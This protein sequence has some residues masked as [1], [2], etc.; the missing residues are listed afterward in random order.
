M[1]KLLLPLSI[2]LICYFN[3]LFAQQERVNVD[4]APFANRVNL[5]A[6]GASVISPE[7][8]PNRTVTFRLNAPN[9][10]SVSVSGSMFRASMNMRSAQMTKDEKGIW[11]VT[12]GPFEPD[13]YTYKFNVDGVSMIDPA[14]TYANQGS[15]PLS[16]ILYVHG[17]EPMYYDA[18]PGVPHGTV[19]AHYY[20]SEVT[21]GI[22]NLFVYTPPNYD[23]SKEYPVLYLMGGSGEIGETW[24]L[25]GNVNFI[26]DNLLAEG[27]AKPMIIVMVNNQLVHRASPN[28]TAVSFPLVEEEYLK[29][30]I[31]FIEKN[32][33]VIRNK[34]GRAIS[35]LSM[36]GRHAQYVG[37][38]NLNVFGS[39]GILSAALTTADIEALKITDNKVLLKDPSVNNQIDYLFIGAGPDETNATAR[40]QLLHEQCESVGIKHE[41]YLGGAAHDFITWRDL[42]YYRFLPNLWR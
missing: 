12:V 34:S 30:I 19:T 15:M 21:K 32:Y 27:K 5:A 35:G 7:V 25:S 6:M 33:K 28:H 9:A 42:L 22:R 26:M 40:H 14:N 38:R 36:G 17:N 29:C 4:W 41:Y 1:K 13:M 18:K 24:W 39:I 23:T 10:T 37:L 31:P 8:N 11:S 20:Y 2:A 16:S 3:P